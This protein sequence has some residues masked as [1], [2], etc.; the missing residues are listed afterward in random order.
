[1]DATRR[2]ARGARTTALWCAVCAVLSTTTAAAASASFGLGAE[3]SDNIARTATDEQ[4]ETTATA[5][6]ALGIE[7]ERPRLTG[8]VDANVQYRSYLDDSFDDELVG[9]ANVDLSFALIKERF[10]WILQD[11]FGQVA[12]DRR[13]VETP[14]NRQNFNVFSTGPVITLP[15]GARTD[16]SVSGLWTDANYEDSVQNAETIDGTVGLVRQLAEKTDLGVFGSASEIE[17]DGDPLFQTYRIKSAYLRFGA[18]G[19]RTTLSVDG[20]YTEATHGDESNSGPLV[21]LSISRRVG[22]YS[23]LALTAGSDFEDTA[24]QFRLDQTQLGIQTS[25]QDAVVAADVFRSN[26]VFLSFDTERD[27]TSFRVGL[28]GAKERH[29]EQTTL[30]RDIV[31]SSLVIGR[32]VTQRLDVNLHGEYM[33]EDFVGAA[34]TSFREWSFGVGVALRLSENLNMQLA[35]DRYDGSG[36]GDSRDYEENRAYISFGYS[37]GRR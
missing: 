12:R 21:H 14:N 24:S 22:A 3:R 16:L 25:N 8:S 18:E 17:Y 4:T 20:G 13:V 37:T 27:R 15:L 7:V 11:N 2:G 33:D 6:A 29:E 1:V 31:R 35:V 9:G 23:M 30:D 5:S 32:Q 36:D 28:S 34:A 10:D 19:A 26:F